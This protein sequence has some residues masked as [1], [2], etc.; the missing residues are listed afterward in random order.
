MDENKLE[1]IIERQINRIVPVLYNINAKE[2][3][4]V[5]DTLNKINDCL[6][7]IKD[8]IYLITLWLG[9]IVVILFKNSL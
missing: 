9:A 8:C 4:N 1:Q 3:K 2:D 6:N 7:K 5:L